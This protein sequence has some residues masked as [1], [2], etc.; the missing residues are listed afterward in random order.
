MLREK[1]SYTSSQHFCPLT[2]STSLD[3]NN[4]RERYVDAATSD[5]G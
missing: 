4:S 2:C 3:L 5:I 1:T